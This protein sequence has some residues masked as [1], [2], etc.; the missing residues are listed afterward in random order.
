MITALEELQRNPCV[1]VCVVCECVCV[2]EERLSCLWPWPAASW[3]ATSLA[4]GHANPT[5]QATCSS[6]RSPLRRGRADEA[7]PPRPSAL[8]QRPL[9]AERR[10]WFIQKKGQGTHTALDVWS[11]RHFEV[12][13]ECFEIT[14]YNQYVLNVL[15]QGVKL[16]YSQRALLTSPDFNSQHLLKIYYSP[17]TT[18]MTNIKIHLC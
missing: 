16:F 15:V 2:C 6:P 13:F 5:P 18:I 14:V 11:D 9:A 17:N 12:P 7:P 1:Y 3:H 10:R 8:Q 4:C